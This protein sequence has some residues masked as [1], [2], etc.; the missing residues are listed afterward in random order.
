MYPVDRSIIPNSKQAPADFNKPEKGNKET[1]DLDVTIITS[2]EHQESTIFC[3]CC[4]NTLTYTTETELNKPTENPLV[5]KNL[6]PKSLA[7][8]LLPQGNQSQAKR[9]SS[10]IVTEARVI[11]GDEMLQKLQY[12]HDEAKKLAEEKEKRKTERAIKK[13][14]AEVV[15]E[16]KKEERER[17]N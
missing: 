2:N 12:K 17:E 3:L 5:S 8:V 7:D 14:E 13:E 9:T 11:T 6:I 4:G 16:A 15:K 1:T 10:K